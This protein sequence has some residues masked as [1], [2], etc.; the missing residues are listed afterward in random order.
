LVDGM[1]ERQIDDVDPELRP[2]LRREL[3][4][5]DDGA[6]RAA[7][8]RVED[9]EHREADARGDAHARLLRLR[10]P[11]GDQPGDVRAMPE[12]VEGLRGAAGEIEEADA[13][14]V[15]ARLQP[16]IDDGHT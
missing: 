16:G 3:D 15:G 13:G 4:R 9:L 14:D 10:A 1:A 6:R 7:A 2:V 5:V 8:L 12:V 11:G